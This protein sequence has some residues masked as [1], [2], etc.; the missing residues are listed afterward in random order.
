MVPAPTPEPDEGTNR[1]QESL[2]P[3]EEE[4]NFHLDVG[5]AAQR[6]ELA[7][8]VT[9]AQHRCP[10]FRTLKRAA[11]HAQRRSAAKTRTLLL[12][13][14]CTT[15]LSVRWLLVVGLI[16]TGVVGCEP[17]IAT[18]VPP[19]SKEVSSSGVELRRR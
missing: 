7:H 16:C 11:K 17:T 10:G 2:V 5:N 1:T 18:A 19:L 14:S 3:L 9:S 8:D 6:S 12:V 4:L 13:V 15:P